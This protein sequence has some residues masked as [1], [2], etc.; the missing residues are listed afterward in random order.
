MFRTFAILILLAASLGPAQAAGLGFQQVVEGLSRPLYLTHA[1]DTRLFVVEQPGRIRSIDLSAG[2][3][4]VFLDITDRVSTGGSEQGLLSV[5]F[6]PQ[7]ASNALFFVNYTDSSGATVV[8]QF[9]ADAGGRLGD[10]GSE[11]V[12]LRVEQPYSNHN[13]GQLKFG[14]DGFLYIGMGDGGARGD[15]LKAGQDN[16]SLL[17]ALLRVDVDSASPYGIPPSNPYIKANGRAEIWASG[18]RNPWR[19][20]F[21][22]NTG[23]LYIGDVGQD[24]F[25]EINFARR[26]VAGLNY[27][28]N[29][30]EGY[31]CYGRTACD[32]ATFVKPKHTYGRTLGC[33]VT[34]GYVYRGTKM[35]QLRGR[36][37]FGD[38]CS[39]A[40]WSLPAGPDGHEARLEAQTGVQIASFGED[41]NG[42]LYLVEHAGRVF[43][44]VQ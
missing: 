16:N 41:L 40:I 21:D 25:E 14:P 34:G 39:G 32:K 7:F 28:W 1:G 6:H 13:G 2:T 43:R 31:D 29:V 35:R 42:E 3:V 4:T 30:A 36:Y 19:F 18:L 26:G 20:S 23:D 8:S 12:L 15:P 9:R 24:A 17:G 27:G 22:R 5:A 37:V 44:L 38:Y 11:Q 10:K 33:S